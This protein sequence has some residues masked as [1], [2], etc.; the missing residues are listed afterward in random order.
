M[1]HPLFMRDPGHW[2]LEKG[3]WCY[4]TDPRSGMDASPFKG[5]LR[6]GSALPT[7]MPPGAPP[8]LPPA[9]NNLPK[10]LGLTAD[11]PSIRLKSSGPSS[12]Q[13][14]ISNPS[15]WP[16]ALI[17]TNPNI[18][19][20]T[21]SLDR[22]ALKPNEKAILSI[23]SSGSSQIPKGP[24]TISVKVQQTNQIIPIQVSFVN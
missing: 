7:A 2:K 17:L 3:E 16:M 24:F 6:P 5:I 1:G 8:A 19:G 12:E 15:P 22:L 21:V 9:Q 23:Q 10:G 20:L 4:Y 14:A 13:V 18:A 11:K